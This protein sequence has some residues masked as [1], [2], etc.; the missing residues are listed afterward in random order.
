MA[1]AQ[2]KAIE[3]FAPA[4]INL[5]LHVTGKRLNGYHEIDSL[6]GFADIGDVIR[7]SKPE[8]QEFSFNIEGKFSKNLASDPQ[9]NLVTR[10]AYLLASAAGKPLSC[11]ITLVKNLPVASGIGGGSSD[12]AATIFG[13]QKFWRLDKNAPY[14]APILENLG[15]DV[16]V[17]MAC[18]PSIMRGI[19]E[20]LTPAPPMPET[21]IVLV[22]PLKPCP[23][24][25]V[26]GHYHAPFKQNIALPVKLPR[27]NDFISFLQKQG[28]DLTTAAQ[29]TIPE[30]GNILATLTLQNGCSIAR[31]SG[32][33]AT[34]FGLFQNETDAKN[35]AKNIATENPDWWV[36]CGW[37]NRIARY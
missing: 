33:G 19:G 26:F 31:L 7:I 30:I 8:K 1:H 21:P 32:S 29:Q 9:N 16:P 11:S 10:A 6:V 23:T 28:N 36:K 25:K 3:V 24:P 13:L 12:A 34:C 2:E 22:N 4:K 17:C 27:Y 20:E 18:T 37:L 5:Y 14:I 35:A 15:A